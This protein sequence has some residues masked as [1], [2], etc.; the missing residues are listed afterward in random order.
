MRQGH[1]ADA[2]REVL[3]RLY[4]LG[5]GRM[6]YSRERL[7]RVLASAGDPQL[8][9]AVVLVGGTNGKGRLVTALSAALSRR[10]RTGAFI[11]PHLKS[12]R[13]R[14]RIGDRD[15]DAASFTQATEQAL[16]L[17]ESSGEQLSFFEANVLIGALL[18][19]AA[20]CEIVVWEVGLGGQHDACNLT[21]PFLSV[22]TNVQ[23]DHQ[24]LLGETLSQIAADKAHIVRASRPLLL[25]PPR[26]GWEDAYAEYAP[27]VRSVCAKLGATLIEVPLLADPPSWAQHSSLP[28][29]TLALLSAALPHLAQA[30]FPLADS[31]TEQGLATLRYRG[32][33]QYTTLRG[34]PVLLD[35]AHNP[36][37]L[38]WLVREL[39]SQGA[40]A[41]Y[42]IVFGCQAS[43]DPAVQLAELKPV[44]EALVP[45]E[46]PVLRPCPLARIIEAATALNIAVSLPAGFAPNAVPQDY[47]IGHVTELDPPDNR[48]RWIECV[49]HAL[50]LGTSA[51][52]TVICGSI[53][54]LGEILRVFETES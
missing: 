40:G 37:S 54:N 20:G 24:A 42:P 46:V 16:A 33:M 21:E 25:G 32:R 11:K 49:E 8:A 30:G 9:A 31:D 51:R 29:D 18:F 5:P 10:Y 38:R 1:A 17:I 41:R 23:Y 44:C 52:P 14:W 26:A 2:V 50:S 36:D 45:I 47:D 4:A 53:Y 27:V 13:E 39:Q 12:I 19:R 7:A 48:T 6:N 22:L 34:H 15:V 35:A 28:G 43:R 3:R